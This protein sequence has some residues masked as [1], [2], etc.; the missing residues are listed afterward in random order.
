[1]LFFTVLAVVAIV[2]GM[3]IGF[4]EDTHNVGQFKYPDE[5]IT[6]LYGIAAGTQL[7]PANSTVFPNYNASL[8]VYKCTDYTYTNETDMANYTIQV[9]RPEQPPR[10]DTPPVPI[11]SP[12]EFNASIGFGVGWAGV[13]LLCVI[14]GMVAV[15]FIKRKVKVQAN[16]VGGQLR[17]D[18]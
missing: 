3:N 9:C 8:E 11:A 18:S 5:N 6:L 13:N 7:T 1:M 4:A 15:R 17:K 14:L 16:S 10:N 12:V 2:S